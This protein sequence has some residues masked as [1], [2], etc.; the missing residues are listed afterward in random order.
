MLSLRV[1]ERRGNLGII[2]WSH[3]P[4]RG[5]PRLCRSAALSRNDNR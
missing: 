3:L 2:F 5:L 1:A 4:K